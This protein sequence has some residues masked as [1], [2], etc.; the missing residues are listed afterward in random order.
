MEKRISN[1][2]KQFNKREQKYCAKHG[3][4]KFLKSVKNSYPLLLTA[5]ILYGVC[6]FCNLIMALGLYF[7]DAEFFNFPNYIWY[8]SLSG[9]FLLTTVIWAINLPFYKRKSK[10]CKDELARYVFVEKVALDENGILYVKPKNY[11]F[12]MI[13]RAAMSVY[14]QTEKLSLHCNFPI[15]QEWD[16]LRCYK[17]I[18]S[19]AKDEYGKILK[20]DSNTVYENIDNETKTKIEKE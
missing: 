17:Q 18:L 12:E 4:L 3:R 11:S 2:E 9:L 8:F 15:D 16:V 13:Y 10:E 6:A 5:T 1:L 14:W 20:V 19:A 7:N